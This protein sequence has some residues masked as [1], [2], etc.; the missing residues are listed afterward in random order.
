MV[1]RIALG[2]IA[3]VLIL[4]AG[5]CG[6]AAAWA[7]TT[8]RDGGAIST[9]LGSITP[10]PGATAIL[11]DVDRFSTE[12][13]YIGGLGRSELGV[14]SL[15]PAERATPL[16]LGAGA[17]PD[18]DGYLS[19]TAYAVAVNEGSTWTVRAVPGAGIPASPT[20]QGLWLAQAVGQPAAIS[21]PGSRPLTLVVMH[22]DASEI[23]PVQLSVDFRV[24]TALTWALWLAVAAGILLIAGIVLLVLAVRRGAARGRHARGAVAV[25]EPVVVEEPVVDEPVVE[26]PVAP[27]E[28]VVVEEAVAP[29]E[30]AVVAED[31]T[32]EIPVVTDAVEAGGE[33]AHVDGRE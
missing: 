12:V 15:D 1:K 14:R 3:A 18:V 24:A 25:V 16:F 27:E 11:M 21:V 10:Q 8:F 13:P 6:A 7:Y 9:D 22:P 2:L 17:T 30:P 20:E 26:D 33:V 4:I 31:A 5:A 23:G 19:G 28:P 32:M 29:D